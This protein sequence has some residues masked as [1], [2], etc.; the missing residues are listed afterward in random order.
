MIS[1]PPP[2]PPTTLQDETETT[3]LLLSP[4]STALLPS[5]S[6]RRHH[7]HHHHYGST[8]GD[9]GNENNQNNIYSTTVVETMLSSSASSSS[10]SDSETDSPATTLTSTPQQQHQ[11]DGATAT[12]T[13]SPAIVP[14]EDDGN[15]SSSTTDG[16]DDEEEE[17]RVSALTRRL[18]CLFS[19][20]TWPIVPLGTIVA[21]AL[22]WVLYAAS[23]LD[24]R[25][26]CSH[27]LHW[28]ALVSLALV[29][30]IPFHAQ[31]RSR[32]FSYHRERDGPIRPARVRM[33]D[34]F[35]HTVCL[36][37]VYTGVTL[38]QSC[39][40][41][42]ATTGDNNNTIDD[43]T[44][45]TVTADAVVVVADDD[46]DGPINT[47]QATCPNL[48]QALSVYVATLEIFTFALILPLLFLPCI[49]LWFLR[50][51]TA[52]AEAFA[53]LQDRLQEEEA[54]LGN[55]GVTANEIMD[56]LENVKLVFRKEVRSSS[57]NSSDN[58]N[59]NNNE[60]STAA[61]VTEDQEI[62]L[63]PYSATDVSIGMKS[64]I[65]ECCICMSDFPI[66]NEAD[67]ED[68]LF[69]DNKNHHQCR[70]NNN[71]NNQHSINTTVSVNNH[72]HNSNITHRDSD[73]DATS[74][75]DLLKECIIVRTRCGHV[76]HRECL[77]GWVG[78]RWQLHATAGVTSGSSNSNHNHNH[79]NNL[80][81]NTTDDSNT[82][83]A[84]TTT[85]TTTTPERR[86]RRARQ[87][88]CPL[89]REDLRPSTMRTSGRGN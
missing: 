38:I 62:W 16:N 52:E 27:P 25:R 12:T 53:Q 11:T 78:G 70:H 7:H 37:Y 77:S 33:F 43:A 87:T 69:Q 80:N 36:L 28:Y 57:T 10:S 86:R 66:H 39:R 56:S 14:T 83:T 72:E 26:S 5:L 73:H 45:T 35:F 17:S 3:A 30:Y 71:N 8:I 24:L 20:I 68:G 41:D 67:L 49:Y 2:T 84:T 79:N 76:F 51:A 21:L 59:N 19:T 32:L 81:S 61:E 13:V 88:C 4:P 65:K 75:V 82:T 15:G 42:M 47:C 89:C 58:N 46:D 29:S 60:T 85:T 54:L 23:S 64:D 63:L 44:T 74:T 50:R 1:S 18:R 55:G 31:V 9:N 40:E 48:Y 6:R 22:L 34:Q